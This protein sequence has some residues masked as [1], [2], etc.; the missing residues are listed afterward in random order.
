MADD[1][2]SATAR[3]DYEAAIAD[4]SERVKYQV[5]LVDRGLQSLM[6]INGGALVALFT[7]LGSKAPPHFD[8]RLLWYAFGFFA[9]GLAMT[10]LANLSAFLSQAAFYAVSMMEAWDAQRAIGGLAAERTTDMHRAHRGGL[11]AQYAGVAT[12]ALALF[13]FVLGCGLAFAGVLPS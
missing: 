13:A 8:A 10:L 6:L 7:L 3:L 9:L 4:A 5:A 1:I 11:H 12:A 2:A